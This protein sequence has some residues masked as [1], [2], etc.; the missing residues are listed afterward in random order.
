MHLGIMLEGHILNPFW[1]PR[2]ARRKRRNEAITNAKLKYLRIYEKE[3]KQIQPTPK[4]N[5]DAEKEEERVFTLWLQGENQ[6]PPIVKA[7]FRSMKRHIDMPLVVLDEK[8]IFD[9]IS[10]PQ[11]IMDKWQKGIITRAHFSDICRVELLY[12]HGGIWADATDFFTSPI[13]EEIIKEDFFIL[14]TN[15]DSPIGGS[16]AFIQSC[17][18]RAKKGNPLL[19]LWLKYIYHYWAKEAGLLDYFTLH[20]LFRSLVT[21]NDTAARLFAKMPKINQDA[22]HA[23]FWGLKDTPYDAEIFRNATKDSFFQKTTYK[24]ASALSPKPGTVAEYLIKS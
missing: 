15:P 14:M 8:S 20:L 11:H 18:I 12:R 1:K 4:Q 10:L 9:W 7:C 24:D 3:V 6:A 13:P 2:F 23:M 17:F 21:T 5:E 19:E 16:F 22:T